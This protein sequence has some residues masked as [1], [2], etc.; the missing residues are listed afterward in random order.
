MPSWSAPTASSSPQLLQ[1]C[2]RALIFFICT[3][4]TEI[5]SSEMQWLKSHVICLLSL[6]SIGFN[7]SCLLPSHSV[8]TL[9]GNAEGRKDL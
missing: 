7:I 2:R 6:E 4:L 5:E 9:L 3:F 8:P 1:S